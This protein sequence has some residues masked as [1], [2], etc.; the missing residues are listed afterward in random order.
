[1]KKLVFFLSLLLSATV[2]GQIKTFKLPNG[3]TVI[4]NEDH[5]TPT[6]FGNIVVRAGSVNDPADATGLAHYL[7]HVLFKGS[8]NVGT[9]DWSKE[10]PHY[11]KIIQLY[12]KLREVPE[13]E[14]E[15]IQKEINEE[16]I[17][18]GVYTIN[19]E[20]SNLIQSM[21]GT[22]LNAS[23]GY[24]MTQYF[25]VFPSYQLKKWLDLNL[26]RFQY[27]VFRGFQAELET[28]YEE[29]NM[30]SDNPFSVLSEEF[31]KSFY[32][33]S[34][35]YAR[36]I[37]GET[38][39]LKTPSL[40]KL[41]EFF[42][43]YYVPSNMCI[44]L[45]GDIDVETAK[46]LLE[47]TFGKWN[48]QGSP[49]KEKIAVSDLKSR[50]LIK[51][52]ISPFPL[53]IMGF[54][55][56]SYDN[57]DGD[58]LNVIDN[59]LSN[60]SNTGLLD[61]LVIDNEFM[62]V[63]ASSGQQKYTGVFQI[64]AIPAFD[65]NKMDFNSLSS[66]EK[67]INT[68]LDNV[69]KGNFDDWL[70]QS[71]KDNLLMDYEL[72]KESN[73]SVGMQLSQIFAYELPISD[74]ENYAQKLNA[75]TK[76]KIAE[77]AKKYF[78]SSYVVMQSQKGK[79]AKDELAKPEYKPVVP[80]KGEVS[81][82]AK[83]WMN[84]PVAEPKLAFIDFN[85][86]VNKS[87]L[88]QGITF[89]HT[90][91]DANNIF[92]MTIKYG[93]GTA[94]I[95]ELEYS[96]ELMNRAGILAQFN[97]YELKREFSRLGCV[98]NF[99]ADKSYT[100]VTMRGKEANL[101]KACQLLAKTYLM[102]ALDERQMN[103]LLGAE[104]SNRT[105]EG[106]EKSIQADALQDYL[107]YGK[108]SDYLT[109][110]TRAQIMEFTVSKLAADFIRA[111]QYE[112]TVHYVG[113]F[114][115]DVV[116]DVLKKNLAFPSNLQASS[117]P[118]V[119]P[120]T[121]Y[122]ANTIYVFNNKDARQCDVYIYV[123]GIEY[124]LKDAAVIDAYN[125]Y[126]GG[127][128]SG[129]VLQELRELRSFAY[130]ASASYSTPSLPGYKG[131]LN[132]YIGVQGDKTNDAIDEFVSLITDMP[133]KPERIDNIRQYLYQATIASSPSLRNK[134]MIVERWER[135]GYTKDPRIDWVAQYDKQTFDDIVK[136]YN[137]V[138][139][140]HPIA[141]GIVGNVKQLDM[142]RLKKIGKVVTVNSKDLFKN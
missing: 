119:L 113:G 14:R 24:E 41:I 110:F 105:M 66:V 108:E 141:I 8:E 118:V 51:K 91:N 90:Q 48:P 31:G 82:F 13:A 111:T 40:S 2:V 57:P 46:P 137:D 9:T 135:L 7:E 134:S 109:R 44:V 36:P 18:A 63:Q 112:T 4:I 29:K 139:K 81:A 98:V 27:P 56:A 76:E 83:E 74:F 142:N 136:F 50:T 38:E 123:P 32:G 54:Q 77:V 116:K 68:V 103:S 121:D 94:V 124:N 53:V 140:T 92:S 106:D 88:N 79:P 59:I 125:Q 58:V 65:V 122:N 37:L 73:M 34:S 16:S 30:Y 75:V 64:F 19:N 26:D 62:Q 126:F 96:V 86:D 100:Y 22:S 131:S 3:F 5:R 21:G 117:S 60:R 114:E 25:N 70:L 39:H 80:S 35:P 28:V 45:S 67:S 15:A 97:S 78:T 101:A 72:S 17:L 138:I 71:V 33:A 107:L 129:I 104:L 87:V 12:D 99:S 84:Q 127:G 23:T 61:R 10:K 47:D 120:K 128:F 133:M 11:E 52:N 42:K 43:T 115:A 55:G 85:K 6:I 49:A 1:M 102:P 130:T 69:K 93:V 95:P 89:Y 132:G 20:F